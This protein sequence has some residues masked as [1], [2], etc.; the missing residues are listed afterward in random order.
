MKKPVFR[1][2]LIL[3]A[4]AFVITAALS[5]L[6]YAR[7]AGAL[8][9]PNPADASAD[10]LEDQAQPDASAADAIDSS[11]AENIDYQ[12]IFLAGGCFWGVQKFFDQFD[13]VLETE[14]GYANGPVNE[15]NYWV[16]SFGSGHA[17]TVKVKYDPEVISLTELLEYYFMAIDP[18][19][20]NKQGN[21]EGVQYRTGI[22]YTEESQLP[23]IEA[24][25]QAQEEALGA[26][27]AVEVKPLKNYYP[28]EEEHQKYL[29][30]NPDGYCHIPLSLF[31][32]Q[33]K[34]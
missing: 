29:D 30:K 6:K 1:W 26:E 3:L 27:L 8:K 12:V 9:S 19:S 20:V 13:G 34:D 31:Q 21:D 25:Y 16:V 24:V 18:L 22:Y 7:T 15:P 23:E 28:A 11:T 32:L 4:A 2:I 5:A 33:Q 17:E 14:T 10:V